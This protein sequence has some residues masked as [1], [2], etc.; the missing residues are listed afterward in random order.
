M[1]RMWVLFLKSLGDVNPITL[2]INIAQCS[3]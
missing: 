3:F 2:G 1:F